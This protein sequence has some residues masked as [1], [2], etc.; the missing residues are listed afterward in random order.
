MNI[1]QIKLITRKNLV[2]PLLIAGL[3]PSII[4]LLQMYIFG[5]GEISPILVGMC[6]VLACA[7][8]IEK[9]LTEIEL[10]RKNT[11][12]KPIELEN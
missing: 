4:A 10:T 5:E 6:S 1:K 2:I 8:F 3:I 9:V 12:S 7:I 11:H